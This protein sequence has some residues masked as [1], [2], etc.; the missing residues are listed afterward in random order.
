MTPGEIIALLQGTPKKI[1]VVGDTMH[2]AWLEGTTS[3]CQDGCLKLAVDRTTYTPGG[4]AGAVR[5]L[6]NWPVVAHLVAPWCPAPV[7]SASEGFAEVND[8]YAFRSMIGGMPRKCRLVEGDRILF[9]YD[10]EVTAEPYGY[11]REHM[12][13]SRELAISA[14][15]SMRPDAVLLSGYAKGFLD[16]WLLREVIHICRD[17]LKIPLVADTKFNPT[18]ANSAVLKCNAEY[19]QKHGVLSHVGPSVITQGPGFPAIIGAERPGA[20]C[21]AAGAPGRPVHCVNPVGAGDCFAAHLALALA[22]GVAISE[23]VQFAHAAGRVYV[24]HPRGRPPYPHEVH[25]DLDP[26]AGKVIP[27]L[28]ANLAAL[29]RGTAGR[30]VFT[31]GVF[32]LPHAGHSWLLGW[33]KAQGDC[34][35]VGVNDDIS[36]F[37]QRPGKFILPIAE[38]LAILAAQE[39]VDWIVPFSE[40]TPREIM[41]HLRPDVLVKGAEYRGQ[42]VP[43]SDMAGVTVFA[44]ESPFPGHSS[45]LCRKISSA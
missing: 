20:E 28:S 32:R 41:T 24:Q 17:E 33:A 42:A 12:G 13:H 45:D 4:A 14:V 30:V 15:R 9:R 43:G 5:Q 22:H 31:N 16:Y 35:V 10:H 19:A 2:D 36:A 26:L 8:D 7:V 23:A 25:R 18:A 1:A 34:L 38:R 39:S 37:R 29:R 3:G 21:P 11:T 6:A 44:P 40:D 27:C